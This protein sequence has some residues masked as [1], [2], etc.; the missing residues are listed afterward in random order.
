MAKLSAMKAA[1]LVN[2][3]IGQQSKAVGKIYGA[4]AKISRWFWVRGISVDEHTF[5]FLQ[6]FEAEKFADFDT[7]RAHF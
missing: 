2:L 6:P 3:C 1:K 5:N 4:D 7:F